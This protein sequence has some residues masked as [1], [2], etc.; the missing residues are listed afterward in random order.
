[1]AKTHTGSNNTILKQNSNN[2]L[3]R[4]PPTIVIA[5]APQ[6]VKLYQVNSCH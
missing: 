2:E 6:K 5:G 3:I 1:M 4:T